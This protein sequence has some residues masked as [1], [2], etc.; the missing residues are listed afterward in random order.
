MSI[1]QYLAE[2]REQHLSQLLDFLRIPSVST[3]SKHKPDVRKA[4]EWLADTMKQAGIENVKIME[5]EGHPVVYGDW[6]HAPGK[7]TAL[8]YGH[9]DVQPAEPLDLWET[10]PFEPEIRDNKIFARGATDD[11]AQLYLHIKAVEA[12][13]NAEGSLPVNI[14]F[15]FEGEEEIASPNLSPFLEKH[16]EMLKAEMIV[17]SDGPMYSREQP[18]ICIGLRGLCGFEIEVKGPRS[19]LHSGLYGGGVANPITALIQL[20]AS[21]RN[22][23]GSIA[24]EGF[25]DHVSAPSEAIRKSYEALQDNEQKTADELGVPKLYGEAG[26]SFMERTTLRPTL[27][28]NGIL[29]G[30]Q[31]EGIKTVLPSSALAKMSCRLVDQQDPDEIFDL[32]E[33]HIEKHKPEGVTVQLIRRDRGK[34][35][36]IAPDH[37]YIEAAAKAY[38]AGFGQKPVFIQSGGSIPI[39]EVFS[40]LL[41]AP[42]VMLDLGLPGENMH[43][44]NEHFHLENY[45][46]GLI[47]ICSFWDE[48]HSQ[49]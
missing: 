16:R 4:A 37:P 46:K 40:R 28:L 32:I 21:M 5:T 15:C 30:Y 11:K 23:D 38:E 8:V 44:P 24:V 33:A 47:T 13:L 17:I 1:Q 45:D 19:D 18:S 10:P 42:V 2:H 9:Y 14:K 34:P 31:G 35:Y 36:T 6:L 29:G 27:E 39:V 49:G 25:Y 20:V 48:V 12:Y 43:A 7:P 41:N 3:S 22:E 26:Y